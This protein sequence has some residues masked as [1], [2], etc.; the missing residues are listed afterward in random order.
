M[1]RLQTPPGVNIRI[2]S[3]LL[4]QS[5][6]VPVPSGGEA[7]G[8]LPLPT[9]LEEAWENFSDVMIEVSNIDDESYLF[10]MDQ[11]LLEEVGLTSLQMND[12]RETLGN[13]HGIEIPP[14]PDKT[15]WPK[16]VAD[17]FKKY[18]KYTPAL[19]DLEAHPDHLLFSRAA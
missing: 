3:E 6:N 9:T 17:M 15:K 19:A 1:E 13:R 10:P 5:D 4:I 7:T 14:E 2:R 18:V 12:G 11:D 8:L 16:T